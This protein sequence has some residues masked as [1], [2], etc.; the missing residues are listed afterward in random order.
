MRVQDFRRDFIDGENDVICIQLD[1][2]NLRRYCVSFQ[3]ILL[4]TQ[5]DQQAFDDNLVDNDQDALWKVRTQMT[6]SGYFAKFAIPFKSLRYEHASWG[7]TLAR[8]ARRDYENTVFPAVPQAYSPYRMTYA[9]QFQGLQLPEPSANLRVQPYG[10]YQYDRRTNKD[11]QTTT[12]QNFKAGGEIK[13][14]VL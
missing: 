13:W 6:D 5:R 7:L 14:A 4:G 10:L 8:L 1:P 9:A 2:Q 3:A 11:G 12:E